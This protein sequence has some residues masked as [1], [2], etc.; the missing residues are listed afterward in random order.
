MEEGSLIVRSLQADSTALVATVAILAAACGG[1]TVTPAPSAARDRGQPGRP[2]QRAAVGRHAQRPRPRFHRAARSRSS[3]SAAWAPATIPSQL[4]VEAKVVSDFNASH[5][6]IHLVFDHAAYLGRARR[7]RRPSSAR[8]TAR[9]SSARSASAAPRRSTASGW[10][11]PPYIAKNNY[12]MTQYG[13]GAVDFFKVGGEGQ[14]G[15]PFAIYPSELYYQPDMFDEVGPRRA[16]ARSTAASTQM[17]DGS[18]S[19]GTT[20]RV[21][22]IAHAADRRQERQGRDRG[23]LRP[24]ATSSSTASSRSATTCA[25]L[26]A[27]FG[28]RQAPSATTARPSRSPTPGPTAWKWVYDGIWTDHFIDDRTRS[29]EQP[30]FNA[31]GYP[32]IHRQGRDAARTSC[33]TCAA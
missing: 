24:E 15:I 18:R 23:R 2:G 4:P 13:Q 14:V 3:G 29:P 20:T 5:P 27:Y 8:A 1:T 32:S 25:R 28:R 26:G 9:T 22:K 21:R 10:T 31:G 19:T 11:S 6:N 16:A 7:A 30:T 33:G 17:P 12:D